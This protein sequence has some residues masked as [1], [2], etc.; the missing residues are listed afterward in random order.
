MRA[1]ESGREIQFILLDE[2]E[3]P[4]E[5]TGLSI[6]YMMIKPDQNVVYADIISGVL[7]QTAQMT[8]SSGLGYYALRVMDDDQIIYTG[9]GQVIIDDHVIDDA[10]LNSISEVDGLV[11]P[12]DFLTTDSNVAIISDNTM[13]PDTTWSSSKISG[14]IASGMGELINDDGQSSFETWSSNKIDEEIS[15]GMAAMLDDDAQTTQSTWSSD[16]IAD[17]IS[18]AISGL[19]TYSEDVLWN[20]GASPDTSGT[21]ITL[22]H[23]WTDYDE[24][25]I[26]S[27][28]GTYGYYST[29]SFLTSLFV[30]NDIFLCVTYDALRL[31]VDITL[32]DN[33]HF[34]IRQLSSGYPLTYDAIIG[35]KH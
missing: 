25:V 4:I 28:D 26:K 33:T 8:T 27:H 13:S 6:K 30:N 11:F 17:E 7:Q 16:K 5:L 23:A 32:E 9:Q 22:S 21:L 3:E 24:I 2:S 29:S 35:I 12:D 10:V 1:E 31:G 14:E 20:A 18:D 34:T 19:A 15:L